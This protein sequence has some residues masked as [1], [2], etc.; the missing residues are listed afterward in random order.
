MVREPDSPRLAP[1]SEAL[2]GA[3]R[4]GRS[5]RLG[6]FDFQNRSAFSKRIVQS[7]YELFIYGVFTAVSVAD[8]L[9]TAAK[10]L[11]YPLFLRLF[12][13]TK[14]AGER[15]S[16]AKLASRTGVPLL[17]SE[18]L[19]GHKCSDVLV[20]LGGG[21]SI[22]QISSARWDAISRY[23]TMGMNLWLIHPFVPRFHLFECVWNDAESYP[24]FLQYFKLREKAY[25]NTMKIAI[26]ADG[27]RP[28]SLLA[29]SAEWRAT[30][31]VAHTIPAPARN[32][33]EFEYALEY[34]RGKGIFRPWFRPDL[35]FKYCASVT[36]VLTLALKMGYKKL[37]LCGIDLHDQRYFY[38]HPRLFPETAHLEF[39]P[40]NT[41]HA[42]DDALPWRLPI[43]QTAL[44]M[45]QR[46]LD[47][48][49]LELYVENRSSA[50][51][52]EVPEVPAELLGSAQIARPVGSSAGLAPRN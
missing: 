29:S 49:G 6:G 2:G 40:R 3:R 5:R 35:L 8:R 41:R 20:L 43:K 46:L 27:R 16:E 1:A 30:T 15:A 26:N 37:I 7:R 9:S 34:L 38:Q 13:A 18:A 42:T 39:L 25:S 10:R 47:P 17:T 12:L 31:Y 32:L 21:T 22:N 4:T 19:R 36:T 23:D 24:T 52:P 44:V 48:A 33:R 45:K 50:L 11:P 28:T 14:A 51:W